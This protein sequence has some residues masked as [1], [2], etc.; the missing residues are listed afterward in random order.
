VSEQNVELQRRLTKAFNA[1]DIEAFIAYCDRDIEFH[2]LLSTAVGGAIYH[3]HDGL[4]TWHR[5]LEEAW[6]GEVRFEPEAIFDLGEHTLVY[7]VLHGRGSQ[8]GAV[9]VMP[10][11][12]VLRWKNGRCVYFKAYV[13]REDALEDLG[14]S[15][16]ALVSIA[17]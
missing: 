17:P 10:H 6:G 13:R 16:D 1:R 7:A 8:S 14:I 15:E 9:V 2:A 5:D 4:R 3:G 12:Q 11:G